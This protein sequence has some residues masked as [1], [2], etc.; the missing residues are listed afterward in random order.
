MQPGMF[1]GPGQQPG[2]VPPPQANRGALPFNPQ[3]A[4]MM[5]P[6]MQPG[7]PGQFP[8][9]QGQQ[10]GRGMPN[11]AQQLPPN[12][13]GMA[14]QGIPFN[15]ISQA[16]PAAFP[17]NLAFNQ[18]MA[19]VSQ[20]FGG[21]GGPGVG[22]GGMQGMQNLQQIPPQMMGAN[23]QVMR[24]RDGRP[25]YP[26]QQGRGGMGMSIPAAQQ[27]GGFPPQA[28]GGPM[29]QALGQMPG[30]MQPGI[31]PAGAAP[32]LMSLD[33]LSSAP[34]QQQKQLLGEALYP[35]IQ[36]IQPKLAGK[37]TGMLLEMDNSELFGL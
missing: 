10:G 5:M 17:N 2:F 25:Q 29:G 26:A 14:G 4:G 32:G 24:G 28:R 7:R 37:I 20:Q 23:A 16:N 6:G 13:F 8:G 21:R 19:Q 34:P 18:A 1:Y 22:R 31:A 30:V 3:A 15:M 36:I 35:K 33:A 11:G 9:M 27:M 12:A